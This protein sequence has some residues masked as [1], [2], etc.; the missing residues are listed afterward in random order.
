[1]RPEDV[2]DAQGRVAAERVP[3]LDGHH[4][5]A[6]EE[7]HSERWGRGGLLG[8]DRHIRFASGRTSDDARAWRGWVDDILDDYGYVQVGRLVDSEVMDHFGAVGSE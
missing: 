1:M 2:H 5:E 6:V 3:E 8:R 7:R 4:L